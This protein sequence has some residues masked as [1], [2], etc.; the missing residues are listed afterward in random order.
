[1]NSFLQVLKA[2]ARH[3]AGSRKG[4]QF[5]PGKGSGSG[6]GAGGEHSVEDLPESE[7][8][9]LRDAFT[10]SRQGR[11]L[12]TAHETLIEEALFDQEAEFMVARNSKGQISAVMSFRTDEDSWSLHVEH[13]GSLE[14]GAGGSLMRGLMSRADESGMSITLVS[15]S[16]A[17]GF[18]EKLG[19]KPTGEGDMYSR[20]PQ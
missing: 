1:M 13:I 16:G 2:Q 20:E 14:K 10:E 17:R 8:E 18:Y 11:Q 3:P 5:A 19:F 4:G 6:G 7:V 15:S 9:G 12:Y